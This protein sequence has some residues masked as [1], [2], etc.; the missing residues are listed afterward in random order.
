ME[1]CTICGSFCFVYACVCGDSLVLLKSC[2]G[3]IAVGQSSCDG[4]LM[5]CSVADGV[6]VSRVRG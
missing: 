1:G 4:D 2:E 6:R 3:R 5:G